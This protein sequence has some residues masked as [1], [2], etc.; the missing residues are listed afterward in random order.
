MKT[1]AQLKTEINEIRTK[2]DAIFAR[3]SITDG[4]AAEMREMDGKLET[5]IAEYSDAATYEQKAKSNRDALNALMNEHLAK[6]T[7]AEWIEALNGIGVPTGPIYKMDEVFADPQVKHLGAAAE[8]S[9]PRLGKFKILNQAVKLSRTPATL[10]TAT[11][12]VGQHTDEILAEIG[13]DAAAIKR[14]RAEGVV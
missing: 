10:K 13:Y 4:D 6:K 8:V 3:D 14:L 1:S 12:D 2:Y 5:L 9:H 11:P 7:S